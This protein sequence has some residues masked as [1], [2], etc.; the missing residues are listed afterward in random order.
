[1]TRRVLL[2]GATGFVGPHVARAFQ[3]DG[4]TVR[5]LVRSPAR[6]ASLE[7]DG[8]ELEVGDLD[9]RDAMRRAC[10]GTDV[11]AHLAALTHARTEAE[12]ERVNEGGTR[13][14]LEAACD[15]AGGPSRFVYL[16]SLAA[17]GP[18]VDGRPVTASDTPRPLTAYGRSKLGGEAAC[19]AAADRIEIAILRAP[20]VYGPGDAELFRFFRIASRGLIPV[21]TGPVRPLQLVHVEDLAAAI[22]MAA[23]AGGAVGVY[24]IAEARAYG[25]AEV[26]RLVA[27]AVGAKARTVPVPA[28]LIRSLA[29]ASETGAGVV[30]RSTIFNRDKAVEML[31][32]GWLCETESAKAD[33]NFETRI[34]LEDGLRNTAQWYREQGWL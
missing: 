29:A 32:P 12:Y 2:T 26:G 21:P 22:V 9:D 20:A 4:Y 27:A 7:R 16:S 8:V 14:L 10:S 5:A 3:A 13:R 28:W 30:G 15:V 17:V 33:L 19:R 11:V 34:P 1:M 23:R 6:A 24:H 31:A 18:A 25:W